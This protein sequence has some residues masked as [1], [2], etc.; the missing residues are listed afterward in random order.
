VD[1][2]KNDVSVDIV[3]EL[4]R[5]MTFAL[6]MQICLYLLSNKTRL[7]NIRSELANGGFRHSY[8]YCVHMCFFIPV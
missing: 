2:S 3:F 5:C 8:G 7:L 4:E 6:L 1:I